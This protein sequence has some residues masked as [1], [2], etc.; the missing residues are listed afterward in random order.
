MVL[1]FPFFI[2]SL[3][4]F[5]LHPRNC[6]GGFHKRLIEEPVHAGIN[7]LYELKLYKRKYKTDDKNQGPEPSYRLDHDHVFDEIGGISDKH[8]E[9]DSTKLED[10]VYDFFPSLS[11]QYSKDDINKIR[12]SGTDLE[13]LE[14]MNEA[15]RLLNDLS[16]GLGQVAEPPPIQA[17]S[18]MKAE[19]E[20]YPAYELWGD[21]DA[22]YADND[23]SREDVHAFPSS[24]SVD[25]YAFRRRM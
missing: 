24:Q 4:P 25:L 11:S 12:L 21:Y 5:Q 2:L 23:H 7:D 9:I 15:N 8:R 18:H 17:E 14:D 16:K 19:V 3:C 20:E 13:A 1:L 6:R 10:N 22:Q